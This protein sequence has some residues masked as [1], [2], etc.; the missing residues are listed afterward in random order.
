MPI[1]DQ[2]HQISKSANTQV[3]NKDL[4]DCSSAF[5]AHSHSLPQLGISGHIGFLIG[6]IQLIQQTLRGIVVMTGR[7]CVDFNYRFFLSELVD[8]TKT[9]TTVKHYNHLLE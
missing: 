5:T 6:Q 7:C 9:Q 3:I 2:L 1:F 8:I 4:W